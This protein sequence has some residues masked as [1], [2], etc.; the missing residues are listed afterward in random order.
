MAPL[1][2]DLARGPAGEAMWIHAA[3]GLRLRMAHWPGT[4]GTV[5]VLPGRTEYI[6]KYGLAAGDLTAR[7]Y[8]VV[9][10]DWRGQGLSDH[11]H[12]DP[13]RG[14]IRR[15]AEFQ[16]DLD[17]LLIAAQGLPKPWF[18]L[19][20]SMG[21]A[22]LL[23]RLM[24]PHPF[25]AV[26]FTAPMWGIHL[27]GWFRPLAMGLARTLK[28]RRIAERYL[29]GS[30]PTGYVPGTAFQGNLLTPDPAMWG[31]LLEQMAAEP[32]FVLGG[33]SLNWAAESLLECRALAALPAPDLP[34]LTALG[35]EEQV[36][37]PQAIRARMA[38]WPKG[39]LM[40][41]PG[42]RHEVMMGTTRAAFFDAAD[43]L[44][45]SGSS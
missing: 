15:F 17:A 4:G 19:A 33:P 23:R 35:S 7:G 40:D 16:L 42:E 25:A 9:A 32:G 22:I 11:L 8:G 41:F 20:H 34:C 37:D 3:D 45:R 24:D 44:F 27:P 1:R 12:P 10:L 5:F 26:A 31:Y 2:N 13:A 18:A 21:G 39:R 43:A 28:G 38:A 36:V 30:G 14:H 29:P 6:E